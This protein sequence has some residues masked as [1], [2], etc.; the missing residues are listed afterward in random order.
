MSK[1]T[2]IFFVS[3]VFSLLSVAP[4]KA[5]VASLGA[6]RGKLIDSISVNAQ[7]KLKGATV[8]L[9]NTVDSTLVKQVLS[10]TDGSFR[11]SQLSF[12]R[13]FLRIRFI[14][15]TAVERSFELLEGKPLYDAGTILL[16][17][18]ES[19]MDNIIIRA[20]SMALNGDTTEFN[21][22]QF[23]TIPNAS[24]EDLLKKM[25]GVEVERDGSIKAQGEPV[26]RVL[27]D[28]K[29]LYSN[30]PKMATKNLPADIIEK[31]QV[32]DAPSDQSAFSGF[33]DGT[34]IRTIN[35]ITKKNRKKGST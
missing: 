34:R 27:V 10:G 3:C 26:T 16:E 18:E 5:Q 35:I 19:M 33:D 15:Y 6:V 29:P 21:A 17:K 4:S 8:A 1:V 25:P 2:L 13:Y 7:D 12:G 31:I 32:I 11:I 14:G 30:D 9:F 20:S 23:K 28:G 24:T 22:S